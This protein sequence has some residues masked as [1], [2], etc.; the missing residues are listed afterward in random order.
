MWFYFLIFFVITASYFLTLDNEYQKPV[1]YLIA[2]ILVFIAGLRRLGIDNDMAI[3]I[4]YYTAL[5]AKENLFK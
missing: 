4:E 2:V 1:Y 5:P 3:Y